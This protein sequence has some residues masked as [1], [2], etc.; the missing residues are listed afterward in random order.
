MRHIFEI[1][2]QDKI[3]V[4]FEAVDEFVRD[5]IQDKYNIPNKY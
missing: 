1:N 5:I 2:L 4:T 3:D